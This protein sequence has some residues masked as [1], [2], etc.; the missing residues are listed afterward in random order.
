MILK[1]IEEETLIHHNHPQKTFKLVKK[2]RIL[3]SDCEFEE[4]SDLP[5]NYSMETNTP[6]VV[7]LSENDILKIA[8]TVNSFLIE[9]INNIIEE[10]QKPILNELSQLKIKNA[11]LER[12][13]EQ[14]RT[15]AGELITC[16]EK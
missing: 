5:I 7:T 12:Q 13:I 4:D 15:D 6:T 9:D 1:N 16:M 10:K 14:V 8:K 3:S 2:T 11:N